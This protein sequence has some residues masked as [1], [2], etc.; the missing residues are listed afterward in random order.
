M[1]KSLCYRSCWCLRLTGAPVA[2]QQLRPWAGHI[3]ARGMY[4]WERCPFGLF[5]VCFSPQ[6]WRRSCMGWWEGLSGAARPGRVEGNADACS[7]SRAWRFSGEHQLLR[8]SSGARWNCKPRGLRPLR[9]CQ[10]LAGVSD[11]HFSRICWVN[12]SECIWILDFQLSWNWV[13][14]FTVVS[15]LKCCPVGTSMPAQGRSLSQDWLWVGHRCLAHSC[16]SWA[17][18]VISQQES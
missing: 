17:C 4:L 3:Q 10:D 2:R 8:H 18:L 13:W 11:V 16:S 6:D 12:L 5:S 14:G 1:V 7:T 15:C 9:Q